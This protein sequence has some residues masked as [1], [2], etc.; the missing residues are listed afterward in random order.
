MLLFQRENPDLGIQTLK[1]LRGD[2][3]VV[4]DLRTN[5]L[6]ITAPAEG[7]ALM[8]ALVQAIDVPPNQAKVRVFPLRN[9]DAEQMV[10][11][12]TDLFQ[13]KT[14]GSSGGSRSGSQSQE[15]L[16]LSLGESVGGQEQIS[17]TTDMRTNSVIAAG[18]RGYLD[19]VEQLVLDLDSRPVVERKTRVYAP[20]NMVAKDLA[21]A[22]KSYSDS[23]RDRLQE[24]GDDISLAVK[25]EAEIGAIPYEQSNRIILAY[26]P[27]KEEEVLDIVRQLDQQPAQVSIEVLIVEV[28]CSNSLELGVEWAFQD[29]QYAKAGPAD[30]TTFDFVGG[31]DVGAAGAG[32]GGFTFT[33]TGRDFNFLLHALQSENSL[34]VLSRPHIVAMD[35]QEAKI[36]IT[37][38]IPYVTGSATTIGGSLQTSV[39]RQDVGIKLEVTPQINGR[40]RA[41]NPPGS[42]GFERLD[43]FRRSGVT[44]PDFQSASPRRW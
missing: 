24:L 43:D 4:S 27:R 29:L 16:A 2:V 39:S 25:Q 31:T 6:V 15:M 42:F 44:A 40:L 32:L 21:D 37:D 28:A 3:S 18:T 13:Q 14:G 19:L 12:L 30:T 11:T 8:E 1:A 5:S 36:E 26:S 34:N 20:R 22:I 38:S 23:E 10:N 7:M 9:A 35:N 41:W 17:F 33:I